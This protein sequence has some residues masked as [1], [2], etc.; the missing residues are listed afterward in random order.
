[1]S[2]SP[3]AAAIHVHF[4]GSMSVSHGA[5]KIAPAMQCE[6]YRFR[7]SQHSLSPILENWPLVRVTFFTKQANP[8]EL[9]RFVERSVDMEDVHI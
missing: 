8:P 2:T 9:I 3:R 6:I 7:H 1:M 4:P 5:N